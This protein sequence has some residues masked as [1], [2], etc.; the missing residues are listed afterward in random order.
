MYIE[1]KHKEELKAYSPV[2]LKM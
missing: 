1:I 2:I